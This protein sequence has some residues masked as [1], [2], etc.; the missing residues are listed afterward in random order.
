MWEWNTIYQSGQKFGNSRSQVEGAGEK[1]TH[2]YT[3]VELDLLYR[4]FSS[5]SKTVAWV[6]DF[7]AK[8]HPELGRS[9][10]VCPFVPRALELNTIWLTVIRTEIPDEDQIKEIVGCYRDI[11]LE[12]E[13]Q[14][15]GDELNKAILLIFPDIGS[16]E[17]PKLIDKVQ[18]E[19]KPYF[20]ETGLMIGEFHKLNESPGLH[21]PEFRPLRSPIPMLAIRFMVESDLPFLIQENYSPRLRIKFLEAYLQRLSTITSPKRLKIAREELAQARLEQRKMEI[22][23]TTDA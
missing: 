15:G 22:G 18:Q 6:R 19:L 10:P 5:L 20:V 1:L 4:D 21:N 11:F 13:P 14:D 7:L 17:A 3:P 2:L 16:E 8:P 9:G 23:E 12:L